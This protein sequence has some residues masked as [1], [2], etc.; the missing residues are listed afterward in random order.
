M[1]RKILSIIFIV[2]MLLSCFP[3]SVLALDS[4]S[5]VGQAFDMNETTIE[6]DFQHYFAWKYKVISFPPNPLKSD[7][8][9][10]SFAETVN[11]DTGYFEYFLY[12]YNP[13][14]KAVKKISAQNELNI[15]VGQFPKDYDNVNLT[16]VDSYSNKSNDSSYTNGLIIKFKVDMT[17]LTTQFGD[18]SEFRYYNLA[19]FQL[20]IKGTTEVKEI[21]IARTFRYFYDTA[22]NLTCGH[23]DLNVVTLKAHHTYYRMKAEGEGKY[24]DIQSVYFYVPNEYLKAH[25]DILSSISANWSEYTIKPVL[26]VDNESIKEAFEYHLGKSVPSDFKYGFGVNPIN[27]LVMAQKSLEEKGLT[28]DYIKAHYSNIS[29]FFDEYYNTDVIPYY[30]SLCPNYWSQLTQLEASNF[31]GATYINSLDVL[32]HV[33]YSEDVVTPEKISIHG[34]D[35]L[36]YLKSKNFD[37]S[38]FSNIVDYEETTFTIE[39]TT[40]IDEFR[41]AGFFERLFKTHGAYDVSMGTKNYNNLIRVDSKDLNVESGDIA[42]LAK[43]YYMQEDDFKEMT[44]NIPENHTAY[45]LRYTITDYE[46]QEAYVYDKDNLTTKQTFAPLVFGYT[47][48]ACNAQYATNTLIRGFDVIDVGFGELNSED[49]TVYP[50][51]YSPTDYVPDYTNKEKPP[52]I[53]DDKDDELQKLIDT[54]VLI[55]SIIIG[56][57]LLILVLYVINQIIP[58]IKLFKFKKR[59]QDGKKE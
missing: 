33:W 41:V 51:N 5:D 2:I 14:R 8:E 29:L 23:Y 54:I 55:V 13:A 36:A 18:L 3:L 19:G 59:K 27:S 4:E 34:E 42:A 44:K 48:T 49:Y 40:E 38:M 17:Y 35:F 6:E 24:K 21:S 37:E 56:L 32:N 43:K 39:N 57:L 58:L 15:G 46:V 25:K 47:Y 20:S 28:W 12:L 1:K 11:E 52:V 45:I 26:I 7:L 30:I 16:V 22:G 9:F 10:I 53:S 50:V 31:Q